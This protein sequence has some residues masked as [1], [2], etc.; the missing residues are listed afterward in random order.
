LE[1]KLEYILTHTYKDEMIS[2]LRDHPE[3]FEEAL[4]LALTDKQ[5]Y[6]WRAAWLLWSCIEKN[7]ER[8]IPYIEK[9]INVIPICRDNQVRDLLMILQ[10]ME[11]HDDYEGKLFDICISIWEKIGKQPSVRINAFKMI[12]KIMK[13]HPELSNEID[14]LIEPHYLNS[15]SGGVKHSIKKLISE[16]K[17]K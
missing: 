4:Q 17:K 3:E 15:L 11:I 13:K 7:D 2:Y 10:K 12:L 8:I 9:I 14:Y 1:T 5:P 16:F 6:S